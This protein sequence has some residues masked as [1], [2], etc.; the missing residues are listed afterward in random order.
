MAGVGK[1]GSHWPRSFSELRSLQDDE[2]FFEAGIP[3][4][5]YPRFL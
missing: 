3:K 4:N 2:L 1:R 5:E